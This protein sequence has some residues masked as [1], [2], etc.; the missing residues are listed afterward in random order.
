MSKKLIVIL[1]P[2]ASGKTEFSINIARLLNNSLPLGG[3]V[4]ERG[5]KKFNIEIINADSRQ[6]YKYMDIGTAKIS[7]KE[8]QGVPHHLFSV[9]GPKEKVT[10][11][12]YKEKAER[13]IEDVLA[14]GNIPILVG[15]SML[16]ISA[17]TDGYVFTGKGGKRATP[18]PY[19]LY[20]IGMDIPRPLLYRRINERTKTL[21]ESGWIG[22]VQRLLG[23]GYTVNDP[24]LKSHG[25]REIADAILNHQSPV[26]QLPII[27]AKIRQYAKRQMTWW[28]HDERI[29]WI[30]PV[31]LPRSLPEDLRAFCESSLRRGHTHSPVP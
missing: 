21:L 2:T 12:W 17:I 10:V 28:R 13:V 20:M 6:L 18:V 19:D 8:M 7:T 27:S 14:R 24:G 31:G 16:Y 9:L 26:T 23:M 25:Y 15:G 29:R 30:N 3:R 5:S 22:E 1:G 11:G 4:R